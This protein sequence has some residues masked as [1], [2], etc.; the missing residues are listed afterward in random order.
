MPR[1]PC[2]ESPNGWRAI[3]SSARSAGSCGDPPSENVAIGG[4]RQ[5]RSVRIN[6]GVLGTTHGTGE[7]LPQGG[8]LVGI[9][10]L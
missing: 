2:R 5:A 3:S 10:G 6:R 9:E 4:L 8:A 7:Q 1:G